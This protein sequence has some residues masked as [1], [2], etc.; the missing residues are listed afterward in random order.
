MNSISAPAFLA[1]SKA[2]RHIVSLFPFFVISNYLCSTIL[3]RHIPGIEILGKRLALPSWC[4]SSIAVGFLGGYPVG[5]TCIQNAH[6]TGA[7]SKDQA[8]RMLAFCNNA[9]PAF[10]FGIGASILPEVWICVLVWFIQIL[11]AIITGCLSDNTDDADF[12]RE[13]FIL[14][15]HPFTNIFITISYKSSCPWFYFWH[16]IS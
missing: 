1:A 14:F 8:D 9:G 13:Q 16:K 3:G 11:S 5:A 15:C 2:T 4:I 10:I 12:F 7:L 6:R